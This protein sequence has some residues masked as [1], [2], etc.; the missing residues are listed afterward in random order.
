MAKEDTDETKE[1]ENDEEGESRSRAGSAEGRF[2][3][4]LKSCLKVWLG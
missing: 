1:E 2:M 4:W 3:A